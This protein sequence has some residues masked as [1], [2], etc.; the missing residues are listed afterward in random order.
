MSRVS[1][2]AIRDLTFTFA[3]EDVKLF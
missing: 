1:R 2:L 3:R